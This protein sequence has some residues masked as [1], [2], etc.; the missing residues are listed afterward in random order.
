MDCPRCRKAA[1]EESR[2]CNHCGLPLAAY[3][4][5]G[6]GE[7]ELWRGRPSVRALV[8]PILLWS[9]WSAGVLIAALLAWSSRQAWDPRLG[10][11]AAMLVLG[12]VGYLAAEIVARK[13]A[14]RYAVTSRRLFVE[15]GF[16]VRRLHETDLLRVDDV[17]VEQ[18]LPQRLADVGDVVLY[19]S[20][21]DTPR[22]KLMG[23]EKPLRVK[24]TI[25]ER[26][27]QLRRD[28]LQV[29]TV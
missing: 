29:R 27:D 1:P 8:T 25:R 22:V 13:M 12:P 7:I 18:S 20:D 21:A 6:E 5:A 15:E 26:A 17:V 2:Y 24:E 3:A 11:G 4:P 23:V 10:W 9:V 14:V 28:V 19:S 16:F